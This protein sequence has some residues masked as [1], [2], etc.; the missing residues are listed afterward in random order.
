MIRIKINPMMLINKELTYQLS[1][2]GKT[3]STTIDLET[4]EEVKNVSER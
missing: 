2:D 4:K 3:A 1:Q